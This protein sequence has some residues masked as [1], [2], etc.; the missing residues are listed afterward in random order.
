MSIAPWAG[1][2]Q[3]MDVFPPSSIPMGHNL[4]SLH[5]HLCPQLPVS[6][7]RCF[8]VSQALEEQSRFWS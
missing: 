5:C 6:W 7:F 2:C 8:T 3:Q 1:V 4:L